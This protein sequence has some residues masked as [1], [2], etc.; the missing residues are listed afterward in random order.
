MEDVH[1]GKLGQGSET[2][3]VSCVII[4]TTGT[5]GGGGGGGTQYIASIPPL[6]QLPRILGMFCESNVY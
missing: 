3:H 2:K 5:G 1:Q 6:R 4:R